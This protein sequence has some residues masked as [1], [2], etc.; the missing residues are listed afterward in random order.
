VVIRKSRTQVC[1]GAPDR[2]WMAC[3][4]T[5]HGR[6]SHLLAFPQGTECRSLSDQFTDCVKADLTS[7]Q[8]LQDFQFTISA[9]PS[10]EIL[11]QPRKVASHMILR[12]IF[13][14]YRGLTVSGNCLARCNTRVSVLAGRHRY[15]QV[16]ALTGNEFGENACHACRNGSG[17]CMVREAD[18]GTRY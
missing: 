9:Q 6:N 5:S 10:F 1:G 2:T 3:A 4:R 7:L 8:V 18:S 16:I 15:P 17:S 12:C 13:L 11:D 14:R